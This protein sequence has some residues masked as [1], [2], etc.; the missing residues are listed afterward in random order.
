MFDDDYEIYDD[1]FSETEDFYND[2]VIV[3]AAFDDIM[4]FNQMDIDLFSI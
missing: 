4:T 2:P 3:R 1:D